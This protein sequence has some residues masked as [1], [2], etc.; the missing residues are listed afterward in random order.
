MSTGAGGPGPVVAGYDGSAGA[1]GALEWAADEAA[2][3]AVGLVVV[4][5][6]ALPPVGSHLPG[7]V[8]GTAGARRA[9]ERAADGVRARHPGLAVEG[10]APAGPPAPTLLA[11][12]TG[13]SL[14]VVGHRGQGALA[15]MGLGTVAR[16]CVNEAPCPV[17]VIP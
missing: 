3:R 1:A 7:P 10:V 14:L 5:V 4:S 9:V 17:A 12:A 2:R 6:T 8:G 16:A 13:A 15:R 11:L